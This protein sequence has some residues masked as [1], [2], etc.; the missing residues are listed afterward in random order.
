MEAVDLK[1]R[2][3]G[4]GGRNDVNVIH[5]HAILQIKYF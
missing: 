4:S 5:I 2:M 3:R 1:E